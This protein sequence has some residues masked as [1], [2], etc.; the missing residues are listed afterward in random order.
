MT[1]ET[2]RRLHS[3]LFLFFSLSLSL[4]LSLLPS[5]SFSP[6][7]TTTLHRNHL[8]VCFFSFFNENQVLNP[9]EKKL[10]TG[11]MQ[12]PLQNTQDMQQNEKKR[13]MK[14]GGSCSFFFSFFLSHVIYFLFEWGF[15]GAGFAQE[16]LWFTQR[17]RKRERESEWVRK[18]RKWVRE[19]ERD[20]PHRASVHSTSSH[21][22]LSISRQCSW[23]RVLPQIC[24]IRG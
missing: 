17:E 4:S 11:G 2:K 1:G 15:L 22:A 7:T 19:R 5:S 18:K 23:C 14:W 3:N 16:F 13:L 20:H 10:K 24:L 6:P 21:Q 12:R 8:T 9:Q